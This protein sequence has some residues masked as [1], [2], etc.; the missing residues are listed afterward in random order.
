LQQM[1]PGNSLDE[2]RDSVDPLQPRRDSPQMYGPV[3]RPMN[4]GADQDFDRDIGRR[5]NI[6]DRGLNEDIVTL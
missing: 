1:R 4:G 3:L 5:C 6:L 2:E